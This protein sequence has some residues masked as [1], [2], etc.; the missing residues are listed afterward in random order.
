MNHSNELI[1]NI[2]FF[3]DKYASHVSQILTGF[4]LLQK[5][6]YLTLNVISDNEDF[7]KEGLYDHNSIVEVEINNKIIVY[8]LADGYQSIHRIDVFDRHLD[9][10]TLY[11]KRSFDPKYHI[12]TRNQDKVKPLGLNYY[13]TCKGNPFDKRSYS[14]SFRE[15]RNARA[16]KAWHSLC[17]YRN[18]VSSNHFDSYKLLFLT[19]VWDESQITLSQIQNAYPYFSFSE[20]NDELMK[21]KSSL[22]SVT[23]SRISLLKSLS[24]EFG[25]L[26]VGG[27]EDTAFARRICPELICSSDLTGKKNFMKALQRNFICIASVGLHNSIGWKFAE[28]VC[29]G[30][31][32]VSDELKYVIP[33][34]FSSPKNYL[35]YSSV[36]S[37]IENCRFLL[38][39]INVIHDME[40]ANSEYYDHYLAPDVLVRNSLDLFLSNIN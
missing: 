36:E 19:R 38:N 30:R 16:D 29:N 40:N 23:A 35:R 31:A 22:S 9:R 7:R 37:C 27:V 4:A 17:D 20:A 39:H 34:N 25:S 1:C 24:S 10:V 28:Y 12:G 14:I 5:Q 32:I 11:F 21:W 2:R 3:R 33:G 26:L 6:G 18:F 8:D 15:L 13:C